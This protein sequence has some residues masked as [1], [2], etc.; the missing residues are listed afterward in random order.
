MSWHLDDELLHRWV[1]GD[2]EA[3]ASAS[4]EQH[5]LDCVT[6]RDRVTAAVAAEPPRSVPDLDRTWE[7][8]R[9]QV[10]AP[11]PS[12]AERA[13]TRLGVTPSEARLIAA[14]PSFHG[15]WVSAV[16]LL[17]LFAALTP[18]LGD[19]AATAWFL[20]CAPL[21]PVLA[22][23]ASYGPE[24]NPAYEQELASGYSPVRLVL[25]RT[26]G[27]LALC[28]PS[29]GLAGLALPGAIGASWMVPAAGFTAVL[30]AASTWTTPVRAA[31]VITLGWVAAVGWTAATRSAG[32]LVSTGPLLAYA[33]AFACGGA[34][35][36]AR[37]RAFGELKG[38]P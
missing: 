32:V 12:I 6:C 19:T 24:A 20:V 27:V 8:V 13:L 9:Q 29:F 4:A 15:A 33:L 7:L 37:T 35:F 17:A 22:V 1:Q 14:A 36:A 11:D 18:L 25:L 3:V 10:Q 34:I 5:V 21:V 30:L 26:A 38:M 23:A 16:V 28:V 31:A 2:A